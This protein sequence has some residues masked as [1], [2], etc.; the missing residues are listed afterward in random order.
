MKIILA[1]DSSYMG[2]Y[3]KYENDRKQCRFWLV[4]V[5]EMPKL[6]ECLERS[7]VRD[8]MGI[9]SKYNLHN[10]I[11]CFNGYLSTGI[12]INEINNLLQDEDIELQ[13]SLPSSKFYPYKIFEE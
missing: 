7:D 6:Y 11:T 9:K 10:K 8:F 1:V 2:Y 5:L 4:D 12:N 3:S 13:I